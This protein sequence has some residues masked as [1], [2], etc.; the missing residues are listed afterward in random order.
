MDNLQ[1]VLHRAENVD[2]TARYCAR[3]CGNRTQRAGRTKLTPGCLQF[4]P[5]SKKQ[6]EAAV[7][8]RPFTG[9]GRSVK[10]RCVNVPFRYPP[11]G[12]GL[13]M[14]AYERKTDIPDLLPNVR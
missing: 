11:H 10:Q 5:P 1:A 2:H 14:S 4:K 13:Y 6:C 8:Q 9:D 7:R 3:T 12:F